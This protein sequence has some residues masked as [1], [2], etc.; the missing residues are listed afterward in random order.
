MEMSNRDSWV[1]LEIQKCDLCERIAIWMHPA[2]GF[3]CSVCP[4]PEQN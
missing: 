4:K 1:R 2:G 3:R